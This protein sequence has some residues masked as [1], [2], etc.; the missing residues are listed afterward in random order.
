[1]LEQLLV[2]LRALPPPRSAPDLPLLHAVVDEHPGAGR[3]K[4]LRRAQG[5][6]KCQKGLVYRR[7]ME[8]K[9]QKR[10]ISEKNIP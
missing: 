2:R 5:A 9:A 8:N 4:I 6:K 7:K 10:T 3:K 1:M